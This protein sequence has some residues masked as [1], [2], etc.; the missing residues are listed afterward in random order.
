M[1]SVL[2]TLRTANNDNYVILVPKRKN[3]PNDIKKQVIAAGLAATIGSSSKVAA[4]AGKTAAVA[5]T[6]AAA[7]K[8]TIGGIWQAG[9]WKLALACGGTVTVVVVVCGAIYYR[10]ELKGKILEAKDQCAKTVKTYWKTSDQL[11]T[12]KEMEGAITRGVNSVSK[13][14]EKLEKAE[15]KLAA[16]LEPLQAASRETGEAVHELHLTVEDLKKVQNY[17]LLIK[18][19]NEQEQLIKELKDALKQEMAENDQLN[20]QL[21]AATQE[22]KKLRILVQIHDNLEN[23][24]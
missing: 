6:K 5:S 10:E 19:L 14:T 12:A 17:T 24:V 9:G 7:L 3:K 16:D 13:Q 21:A 2:N 22:C 4:T 20:Q 11:K 1:E 23:R 18:K 8:A 15:E